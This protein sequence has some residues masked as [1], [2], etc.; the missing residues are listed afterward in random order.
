MV[1]DRPL[2]VGPV[3]TETDVGYS[4][5][6]IGSGEDR[7]FSA[8]NSPWEGRNRLLCDRPASRGIEPVTPPSAGDSRTVRSWLPYPGRAVSCDEVRSSPTSWT[9]LLCVGGDRRATG[10]LSSGGHGPSHP[11]HP[12]ARRDASTPSTRACSV[13]DD[14]PPT[15]AGRVERAAEG[16]EER[17]AED[18]PPEEGPPESA[19]VQPAA[20]ESGAPKPATPA[21]PPAPTAVPREPKDTPAAEK[22]PRDA[23]VP[24]E[25]RRVRRSERRVESPVVPPSEPAR[26]APWRP[27]APEVLRPRRRGASPGPAAPA[28]LPTAEEP[29]GPP[30]AAT[31]RPGPRRHKLAYAAK[32]R[33]AGKGERP[34][35][36]PEPRTAATTPACR[37]TSPRHE[38]H[39]GPVESEPPP[40]STA[41]KGREPATAVAVRGLERGPG[42][43]GPER[44]PVRAHVSGR[45]GE[46]RPAA[47]ERQPPAPL[48]IAEEPPPTAPVPVSPA[49][50]A[51]PSLSP[52]KPQGRE[53]TTETVP[54]SSRQ[55]RKSLWKSPRLE[56]RV[57]KWKGGDG[58]GNRDTVGP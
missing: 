21:R 50:A 16:R 31:Q 25:P 49:A 2:S 28:S 54:F 34:R 15:R 29:V 41:A 47:G 3:F 6:G 57:W 11:P 1:R 58:C 46:V 23:R 45:P 10:R 35:P 44:S 40:Q 36:A 13:S 24:V 20:E 38:R 14:V 27:Q 26:S 8:R 55:C 17:A 32:Q 51:E 18:L 53:A 30:G 33:P 5:I 56:V 39:L 22:G 37:S 4:S 43:A 9:R 12:T 52:L 42:P 7:S 19:P 48:P